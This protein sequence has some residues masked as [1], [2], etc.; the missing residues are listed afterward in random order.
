MLQLS[1][2]VKVINLLYRFIFIFSV[3]LT[4][5]LR[6]CRVAC[7][8]S[9]VVHKHQKCPN[10]YRSWLIINLLLYRPN[11]NLKRIFWSNST[12][13]HPLWPRLYFWPN[14]N[15]G[16]LTICIFKHD[17][18]VLQSQKGKSHSQM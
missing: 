6:V 1:P 15:L 11:N 12:G 13:K 14:F 3:T 9:R 4:R 8:Y 18:V 2:T 16:N 7:T 10:N 5:A 17:G